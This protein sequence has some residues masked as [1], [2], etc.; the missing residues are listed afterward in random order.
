[1]L[2]QAASRLGFKTHIFCP[3]PD[4]PAFQ[5]TNRSTIAAYEDRSA[6][7]DF[8]ESVDVVTYEFENVPAETAAFLIERVRVDPDPAVLEITQDRFTEKSF[9]R[10]QDLR[11]ADFDAVSSLAEIAPS[12]ERLGYPCVLKTRKLG[13]DGKGQ[14]LIGAPRDIAA[15][16][17]A[18][19][20][21]P[22]ILES[23]VPFSKE[24]SV[25]VARAADASMRCFDVTENRHENH[26][27]RTSTV[28]AAISSATA[29]EALQ[30]GRSIAA[31]LNYVGVLVVELFVTEDRSGEALLVNEI[32]PRVHNSGH[33]TEDACHISQFEMHIRAI[34]GWPLPDPHRHSDVQMTNL[35]GSEIY[36][37]PRIAAE[38]TSV[39]HIYGK[40]TPRP[41]RKLGHVNRLTPLKPH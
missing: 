14:Q 30:T 6:L 23:F 3:D 33:W 21:K 22:S 31:A 20:G 2:S 15:A 32:A 7:A 40:L 1:M 39:V 35:L 18:I 4:S 11:V 8:A 24:I 26:I 9:I 37:F 12:A 38:P 5:V 16:W 17:S 13:Y 10:Q 25:I 36:D 41:G 34:I 28:P 29:K 27:L 19:G